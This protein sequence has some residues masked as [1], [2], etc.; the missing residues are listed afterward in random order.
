MPPTPL[1][2]AKQG[3]FFVNA[4]TVATSFPIGTGTPASGHISAKG[5]YA[6][7]Q[8]PQAR[9]PQVPP[10]IPVYVVDHAGHA[11]SG[12]DPS[13]M[14]RAKL[15]G[16]A[17]PVPSCRRFTNEQA[18]TAFRFGPTPFIPYEST[19]YPVEAQD[20]YFAQL[21]PD[22]E[23][24]YPAGDR[25]MIDAL[26]TLIDQVGPAVVLAHSRSGA[27]GIRTAIARPDL[28]KAVVSIEPRSCALSDADVRSVFARVPLLT[29][30]SSA[31]SSAP[32]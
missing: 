20:Q 23:T 32:T 9:D 6:Q 26:A 10:I 7:H 14:N 19:Q 13:P 17:V 22:T 2:L 4:G 1:V 21:V 29:T 11:R 30:F 12:F 18:W 3:S 8:I 15:E 25:N 5:M 24:S 27:Y 31:T 28:V 16:D